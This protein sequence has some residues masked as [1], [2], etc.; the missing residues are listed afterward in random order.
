MYTPRISEVNIRIFVVRIIT[1]FLVRCVIFDKP[2][3]IPEMML[4]DARSVIIRD[5]K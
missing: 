5:K 2:M 1:L 4:E 3:Y